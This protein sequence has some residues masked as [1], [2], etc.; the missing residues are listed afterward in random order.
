VPISREEIAHTAKEMKPILDEDWLMACDTPDGR[1]VGIALTIPDVNQAFKRMNGRILPFGWAKFLWYKPR[2]D[3]VRVGFLGVLPEYQHTGIAAA[4]YAEHFRMAA[5]KR[6]DGGEA[7]WILESNEAM[8]RGLEAMGGR[9]VK[10][11][12]VYERVFA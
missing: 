4:M 8:N 3:R 9:I 12:R 5:V 6:Q 7:G 1:T 11:Y 10:R 2:V